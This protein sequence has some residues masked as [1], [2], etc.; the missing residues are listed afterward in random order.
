MNIHINKIID[1][2]T[3]KHILV[4]SD[5]ISDDYMSR[6]LNRPFPESLISVVKIDG[7]VGINDK[8]D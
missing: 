5:V 3:Q 8:D 2:F 1:H 7:L 6:K 4:I